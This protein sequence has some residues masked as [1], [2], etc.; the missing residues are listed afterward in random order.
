MEETKLTNTLKDKEVQVR[1][2]NAGVTRLLTTLKPGASTTV[3][4]DPNATYKEYVM[5]TLPDNTKLPVLSSD[6]FA[7]HKE[8]DIVEEDN[9]VWKGTVP[10]RPVTV[11]SPVEAPVSSPQ[12]GFIKRILTR[13]GL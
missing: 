2:G 3:R 1:E 7:D 4:T 8:I 5:M 10:R 12:P 13:F 6:D 11:A 9:V